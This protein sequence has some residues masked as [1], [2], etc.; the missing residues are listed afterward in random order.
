M[1]IVEG[2]EGMSKIIPEGTRPRQLKLLYKMI[3][4]QQKIIDQAKDR[5]E[6]LE[7]RIQRIG[8]GKSAL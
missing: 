8:E 4:D 2:V 6:V 7:N 1:G 3:D 5:I